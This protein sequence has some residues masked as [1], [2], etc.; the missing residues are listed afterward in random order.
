[1]KKILIPIDGSEYSDRAVD[2]G[3][4]IAAA[5]GSKVVLLNVTS[6]IT[7]M[8]YYPTMRMSQVQGIMDW[9]GL[10]QKS[11]DSS[12]KT[13]EDAKKSFKDMEDNV[14]TVC[15]DELGAQVAGAIIDY[16]KNNDIDMV[17]MGSKGVGS[18][19]QRMYMGSVTTKILH[20]ISKPVL[21]VQ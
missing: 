7:S 16:V 14:E 5:F 12:C 4:K 10:I 3:K 13:L 2:A 18:L 9:D 19:S 15:V 11:R 8:N 6:I 17:I 1:M 21:V 20:S